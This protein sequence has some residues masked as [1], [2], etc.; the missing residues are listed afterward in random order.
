VSIFWVHASDP[1][2]FHQ[3]FYQIAES[4]Q[5]PGYDDPK[6]D[7]LS[8]VRAWLERKDQRPWLMITDNA[9]DCE[10]FFDSSELRGNQPEGTNQPT[11]KSNLGRYIPECSH[12]SI[13]ITT[14]NKQA[15]VKLTKN[16]RVIEVV[17]M[18]QAESNQLIYKRLENDKLDPGQVSL[19]TTQLENLPLALVQAAA[20]IQENS[21]TVVNYLEL[22]NESDNTLVE[23]LSQ[24][25]EELGRDSTIPNAV[26]ATW[27]IS[28][29]QIRERYPLASDLL[30]LLSYF[31]RQEIPKLFILHYEKQRRNQEDLQQNEIANGSFEVERALG[32]LKAFSFVKENRVSG[33]FNMHRLIQLVMQ[34]WL[35]AGGKSKIW[36]DK[37]LLVVSDLYP[38]GSYENW[39][40]CG[41]YL[42]HVYAVLSYGSSSTKED[43]AK[44]SLLHRTAGFMLYQG[45][46][47][48]AEELGLQAVET[49]KR[50]LGT[51]HP[52]TLTSIGNLASTYKNQGR[53]KEAEDLQVQVMET[54]KRVLGVG[55]P[56]TLTSIGNLALT[57]QNQGRW[58]EAEDLEV[59]VME[60]SLRVLGIENLSTLTSIGN[61]A[62]TYWNQGRWKEAED[63]QV[64]VMETR[65][66][67]LGVEHLDTLTS[68]GNL[69]L[70]YWNQGR[71][72]EAEDLQVRVMEMRKRVLGIEH[73]DTLTSMGNLASTY[74]NQG[75]W[76]EAEDL[77]VQAMETSL[78]VLG[79]EHPG[80]LT[81]IGNLALTY[82]NQ[83]RWKESED[84]EVQVMET[85]LRVLGIEHPDTLTSIGNLASTYK[86]KGRWKEAEDLEVQVMETSLRVLGIEHPDTLTSMNNLAHTFYLRG[87]NKEAIQL[88]EGV[89]KSL[90]A[91]IGPN[92]PNTL[93]ASRSLYL[94]TNEAS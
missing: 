13:L 10:M 90:E 52:D 15:G 62:L 93:E 68:I 29:K 57:Y 59:Q 51:E 28:F 3:S 20:F 8:L 70:T 9:D 50:V 67:V 76:K 64:Q 32:I 89:V 27:V 45:K 19:L 37:A 60:T 17:E 74:W 38:F 78:R 40:V 16:R 71:W 94:W 91:I 83:G 56:G 48:K 18:D 14:R 41:D 24:P 55:H 7:I 86:N 63:L 54:R 84:L 12:G 1:D 65:K 81:S 11:L 25:F 80:T 35:T 44:A 79:V 42:P 33:T 53:W 2:R 75:R 43:V 92:H 47:N 77:Q 66:R 69:A 88:M 26:T 58:K 49:R 85:S 23:L 73:P 39:T 6:A 36:A 22:L 46:W 30:S 61:L 82:W 21:L 31:N 72:K 4:C 5:I 34:K 87:R